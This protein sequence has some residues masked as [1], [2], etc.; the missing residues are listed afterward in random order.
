MSL[1]RERS[2]SCLHP[3]GFGF[4]FL[5]PDGAVLQSL[6]DVAMSPTADKLPTLL[7]RRI[8]TAMGNNVAQGHNEH[9]MTTINNTL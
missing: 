8:G 4:A 5:A 7:L 3:S 9:A 1:R 6:S 2:V